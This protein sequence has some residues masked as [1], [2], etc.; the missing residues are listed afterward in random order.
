MTDYI[1]ANAAARRV[2]INDPRSIVK[3]VEPDAWHIDIGGK[4]V[5]LFAV[6]TRSLTSVIGRAQ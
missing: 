3:R 2:G 6:V 1:H 5:P 4:R